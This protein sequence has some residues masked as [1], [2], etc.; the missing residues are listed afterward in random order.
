MKIKITLHPCPST[1]ADYAT[2][3]YK[4]EMP[5]IGDIFEAEE[6]SVD[7][8]SRATYDGQCSPMF[9][10]N[11]PDEDETI[12]MKGFV[13]KKKFKHTRLGDI[14][15]FMLPEI[16]AEA[17]KEPDLTLR[18]LNKEEFLSEIGKLTG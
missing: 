15:R 14:K 10:A 8:L 12:G 4:P 17:I 5:N 1:C 3:E 7:L 18:R 2:C 13:I 6:S 16:C 9:G 11:A